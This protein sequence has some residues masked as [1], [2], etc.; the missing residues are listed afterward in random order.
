M[1]RKRGSGSGTSS[2]HIDPLSTHSFIYLYSFILPSTRAFIHKQNP[3]PAL[4]AQVT[5]FLPARCPFQ[6]RLQEP[7]L[8]PLLFS[9]QDPTLICR[10]A[11][12]VRCQHPSSP[13]Q[14]LTFEQ[15]R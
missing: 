2:P 3:P 14:R 11:G 8:N 1:A 7:S 15:L 4:R 13:L 6:A 10:R 5:P 9:G 12:R